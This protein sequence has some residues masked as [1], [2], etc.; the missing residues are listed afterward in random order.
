MSPRHRCLR[1]IKMVLVVALLPLGFMS[2]KVG[3]QL[4]EHEL[5][6][7]AVTSFLC[8]IFPFVTVSPLAP[9]HTRASPGLIFF[10][11]SAVTGVTVEHCSF[12]PP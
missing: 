10:R 6:V 3:K 12:E 11:G 7:T 1:Q 4:L 8:A 9:L 2:K 5:S